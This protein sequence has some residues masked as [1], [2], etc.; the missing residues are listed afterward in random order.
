M[1][2]CCFCGSEMNWSTAYTFKDY[3]IYGDG[4]IECY[5]C[6]CCNASAEFYSSMDEAEEK[7]IK[8][9]KEKK[10]L[11]SLLLKHSNTNAFKIS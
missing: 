6:L 2:Y 10:I 3:G 8:R 4:D 11:K 7:Q 1:V 9:E 5:S